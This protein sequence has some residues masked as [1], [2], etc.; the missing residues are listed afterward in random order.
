MNSTPCLPFHFS[1]RNGCWVSNSKFKTTNI[2][3]NHT[4]T[5]TEIRIYVYL[6][7]TG[8]RSS[9]TVET[10][11]PDEL[12]HPIYLFFWFLRHYTYMYIVHAPII[13]NIC[14]QVGS[15]QLLTEWSYISIL[16]VKHLKKK[17][18]TD[19]WLDFGVVFLIS[20]SS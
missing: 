20:L 19:N 9:F 6:L 2:V 11:S 4:E 1:V 3:V 13:I 12:N 15:V 5:N 14:I 10:L 17:K 7:F 8:Y 18:K 16:P